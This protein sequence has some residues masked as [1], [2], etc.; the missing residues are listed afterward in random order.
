MAARC[1]ALIP[2]FSAVLF[3]VLSSCCV[4][5]V[6]SGIVTISLG[7]MQMVVFSFLLQIAIDAIAFL[8]R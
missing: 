8:H 4:S 7:E 2:F 1:G 5:S 3:S 6:L